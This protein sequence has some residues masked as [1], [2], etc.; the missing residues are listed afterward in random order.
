MENELV[1][2]HARNAVRSSSLRKD[3]VKLL[4]QSLWVGFKIDQ[5]LIC[6]KVSMWTHS[7][8]HFVG[9]PGKRLISLLA[10]D[11]KR[12]GTTAIYCQHF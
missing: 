2:L 4:A 3:A 1:D 9:F 7:Y 6:G 11:L 8:F 10:L 12:L 5:C